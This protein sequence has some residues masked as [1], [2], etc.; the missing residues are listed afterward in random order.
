MNAYKMM[1]VV[2]VLAIGFYMFGA[3]TAVANAQVYYPYYTNYYA[4]APVVVA[5]APVYYAP[6]PVVC[7]PRP[8]YYGGYGGYYRGGCYS[9]PA[10]HCGGGRSWGFNFGFGYRR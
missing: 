8:V 9:R 2:G 10:Y 7:Y 1:M 5:P 3:G 4:P 6:P